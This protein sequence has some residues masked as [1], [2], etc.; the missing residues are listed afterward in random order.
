MSCGGKKNWLGLTRQQNRQ[1][2]LKLQ[3]IMLHTKNEKHAP[4][5][6]SVDDIEGSSMSGH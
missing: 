5:D 4:R 3:I 1:V 6:K 2:Q